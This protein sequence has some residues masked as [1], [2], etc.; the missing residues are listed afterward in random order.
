MILFAN[1]PVGETMPVNL[2]ATLYNGSFPVESKPELF[3]L[4]SGKLFLV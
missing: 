1:A 3:V 4:R 2:H